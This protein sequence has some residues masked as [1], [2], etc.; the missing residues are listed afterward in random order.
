[1][2]TSGTIASRNADRVLR[3]AIGRGFPCEP[4]HRGPSAREPSR[5]E[6][7]RIPASQMFDLWARLARTL[8]APDL[9]VSLAAASRLEDLELLGFVAMTAPTALA[10]MRALAKYNALLNDA[11]HWEIV[12]DARR[13]E[14]RRF[15]AMPLNLG[16]RLSHETALAQALSGVRQLCGA[17]IDPIAVSFRH[18]APRDTRAHR[19]FFA[20]AIA[21]DA[22]FDRIVFRREPFD[23]TPPG[24]NAALG[25]WLCAQADEQ[26]A[27]LTSRGERPLLARVRDEIARALASGAACPMPAVAARLGLTPRTLRRA[28]SAHATSYRALLDGARREAA[29]RLLAR[30]DMSITRAALDAGFSDPSAFTHACRRWFGEAPR[31]RARRTTPPARS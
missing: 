18:R 14:V 8:D 10:G 7:A 9:P 13:L 12:L 5:R 20:T 25:R 31:D 1:M 4:F 30:P 26:L 24:A 15:C 29:E 19:D 28:L 6:G 21:F 22:P 17:R 3:W 2:D 27:Q 11:V 16:V 23:G